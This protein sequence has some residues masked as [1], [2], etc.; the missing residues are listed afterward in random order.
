VTGVVV[1]FTGLPASGKST[2]ALAVRSAL[3]DS[4]VL[5]CLLDGDVVR[6][7]LA[8]L[9]D[10]SPRGRR[11]FYAALAALAAELARQGLTVLVPATAHERAFR[12]QARSLAPQF[13][14]VWVSTPLEECRRRD[15]KGLYAAADERGSLPGIGV[16]YEA[17]DDPAV[18]A[19]GGEDPQALAQILALLQSSS[20]R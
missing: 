18:R 6:H 15:P 7:L 1:W 13:I 8:P 17:P 12:H 16:P 3:K 5:P 9:L 14:E 20:E 10:Y 4:G 11:A 19:Q 2:L